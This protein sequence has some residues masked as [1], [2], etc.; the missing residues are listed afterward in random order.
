MKLRAIRVIIPI[1]AHPA[2][3]YDDSTWSCLRPLSII[4]IPVIYIIHSLPNLSISS[5]W[6]ITYIK[7]I[8]QNSPNK[9]MPVI[10]RNL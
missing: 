8:G 9:I 3:W 10:K 7:V 4:D 2:I 5:K 6:L 1:K